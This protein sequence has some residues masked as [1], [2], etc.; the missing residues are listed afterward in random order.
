MLNKALQK[1]GKWYQRTMKHQN[2]GQWKLVSKT[3][4]VQFSNFM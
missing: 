1:E 4:Q 2:K 3:S